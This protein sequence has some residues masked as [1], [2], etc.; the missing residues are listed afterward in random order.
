MNL[1][2][3]TGNSH[4]VYEM[5]KILKEYGVKIK[6]IELEIFE[7]DFDSI[8]KIAKEKARQA[9][10]KIKKPV[11]AEDTGVYF[12]GYNNFPGVMAKR[13]YLGIGFSGLLNLIKNAKNKKCYFKTAVAYFDGKKY[14]VFSG[15]LKGYLLDKTVSLDK[16]RLPYEKLFIPNGYKKALVDI[17]LDE[18]NKISHRAIAT[19]KLGEWLTKN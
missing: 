7:P 6:Q 12:E 5:S 1:V 9:F 16:N 15:K 4:K 18:K 17:P 13:I 3:C 8:E 2:I 14:K 10:E 11:I 19:R